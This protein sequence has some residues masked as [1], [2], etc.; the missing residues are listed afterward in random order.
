MEPDD[1]QPSPPPSAPQQKT[2]RAY[3]PPGLK[4]EE[5]IEVKA[6][7]ASICDKIGG[8]GGLCDTNPGS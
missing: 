8:S 2:R 3:T 7:L 1:S 4:W 6:T 5:A